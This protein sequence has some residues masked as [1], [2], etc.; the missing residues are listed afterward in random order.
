MKVIVCEVMCSKAW[1]FRSLS[2]LWHPGSTKHNI[3]KCTEDTS[4]IMIFFPILQIWKFI[5]NNL[6]QIKKMNTES[7]NE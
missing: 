3:S 6:K 1:I 4:N 7:Y 2:R 5:S